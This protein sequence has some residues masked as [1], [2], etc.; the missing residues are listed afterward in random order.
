[1]RIRRDWD[2]QTWP[3]ASA[4]FFKLK[5]QIP[6]LLARLCYTGFAPLDVCD[7]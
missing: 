1:V 4:G 2:T 3:H 5:A 7:P 6:T